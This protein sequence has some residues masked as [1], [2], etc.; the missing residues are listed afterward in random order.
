VRPFAESRALVYAK[1]SV[2]MV[3]K[4]MGQIVISLVT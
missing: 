2:A 3:A 4:T 1:Q